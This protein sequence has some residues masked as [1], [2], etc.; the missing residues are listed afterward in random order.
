MPDF[1]KRSDGIEIM[2]DLNSSG[3]VI[4]Q[5]LQELDI[6][7]KW[8][9]GNSVTLHGIQQLLHGNSSAVCVADLGCGSGEMLRLLAQQFRKSNPQSTFIGFD[10]NENIVQYAQQH[11]SDFPEISIAADNILSDDF[12]TKKFDVIVATLF[13]HHFT[14]A[15]LIDI[16]K[17]FSR[18][19]R[20]GVVINDLHR[21]WLAYYAIQLLTALFSRSRMVKFDAPLSVLRGFTKKELVNIL[22][23]A[24]ME[25]YSLRWK[26]A[27]RWQIIIHS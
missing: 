24:G 21:H 6:I 4:H 18:Q 5:T 23:Q 15:Q 1:T 3:E 27:F 22:E 20:V 17:T 19:A 11:V 13:L 16:F 26:W 8:L 12:R 7:N 10:A 9:G 2:D 25:H 14:S